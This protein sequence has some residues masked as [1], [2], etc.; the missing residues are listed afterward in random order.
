MKK[1]QYQLTYLSMQTTHPKI[2]QVF[3]G[4]KTKIQTD[5]HNYLYLRTEIRLNFIDRHICSVIL[6]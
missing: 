3:P 1:M 4:E 5:K 6:I 2:K